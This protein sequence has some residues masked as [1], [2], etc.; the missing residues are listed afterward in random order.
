MA[1]EKSVD[2]SDISRSM[3]KYPWLEYPDRIKG[4]AGM[5]RTESGLRV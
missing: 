5:E 1:Y 3:L 4:E 2:I